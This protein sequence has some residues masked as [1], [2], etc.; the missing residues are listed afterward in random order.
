MCY[1][2]RTYILLGLPISLQYF[3]IEAPT[4]IVAGVIR[5]ASIFCGVFSILLGFLWDFDPKE[6][7]LEKI[8][9]ETRPQR[10]RRI[11]LMAKTATFFDHSGSSPG[12]MSTQI[13]RSGV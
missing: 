12:A 5:S 1:N 13:H 6:R 2:E 8:G 7:P 11:D 10:K 9:E 4:T 3:L